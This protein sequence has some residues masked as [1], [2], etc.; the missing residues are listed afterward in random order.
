M[1][2][3]SFFCQ[4]PI[5][6]LP[7]KKLNDLSTKTVTVI[8]AGALGSRVALHLVQLGLGHLRLVDR[9]IVEL[10]NLQR[11]V[12]YTERDANDQIPKALAAQEKLRAINPQVKVSAHVQDV[13]SG[14]IERLVSNC[15]LIVDATDNLSTRFLINDVSYKLNIPWIHGGAI[16]SRGTVAS[17]IPGQTPCYRCLFHQPVEQHGQTCDTIGVLGPLV[18]IVA[19]MQTIMA[20]QILSQEA[21]LCTR[22]IMYIDIWQHDVEHFPREQNPHCPCCQEKRFEFLDQEHEE[23]LLANLCGRDSIQIVPKQ[24]QSVSFDE[25]FNHWK[26]LGNV[27]KTPFYLKLEYHPYELV[28]FQDGRLMVNGLSDVETAKQLYAKLLGT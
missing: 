1:V 10:S 19:S 7:I 17:F 18:H 25:W 13:N 26:K 28:L 14:T 2:G 21:P 4:T 15:D 12:L 8:G 27:K 23:L 11:Q 22:S 16:A 3:D 24:P 20:C 9:D 6:C 5:D